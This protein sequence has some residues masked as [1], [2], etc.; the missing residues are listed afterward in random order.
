MWLVYFGV[1]EILQFIQEMRINEK[2]RQGFFKYIINFWNWIDLGPLV[3]ILWAELIQ[4]EGI[5]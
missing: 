1:I 5:P 2:K 4:R 3:L